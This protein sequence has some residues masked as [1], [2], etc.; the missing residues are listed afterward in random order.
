MDAIPLRERRC[1]A[2]IVSGELGF[3]ALAR[4]DVPSG[5]PWA[6][7]GINDV[8]RATRSPKLSN[9]HLWNWAGDY[10]NQSK[11]AMRGIML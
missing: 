3:Q 1:G 4:A 10:S 11:G 8:F 6:I 2:A 7:N 5:M 9:S